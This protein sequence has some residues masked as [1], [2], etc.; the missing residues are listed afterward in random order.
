MTR[1]HTIDFDPVADDADGIAQSQTPAGAGNF[2]LNGT[3]TSGGVYTNADG[4]ARKITFT[5]ANNESGDTYTITGTDADNRAQTETIAGPNTTTITSSKFWKT[6][7]QIATNGAASGA[8][9][10][11]VSDDL[12]SNTIPLNRFGDVGA[13]LQLDFTG[14]ISITIQATA[15]NPQ[16]AWA[17]QEAIPWASAEDT[18]LVTATSNVFGNIEPGTT[19]IRAITNSFEGADPQCQIYISEPRGL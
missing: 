3:L 16:A 5:S 2:T 13:L 9:T 4:G 10:I 17:D 8:I 19:A 18:N 14:T 6:I 1:L 12:S 7:T 15:A 11:G